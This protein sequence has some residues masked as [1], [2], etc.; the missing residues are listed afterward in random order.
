MKKEKKSSKSLKVIV[1]NPPSKEK[2]AK[3]IRQIS[4]D[5]SNIHLKKMCDDQNEE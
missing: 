3:M 5:I 1:V 4:K 2:A